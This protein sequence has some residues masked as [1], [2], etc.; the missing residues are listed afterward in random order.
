MAV[1]GTRLI[2]AH[3][4]AADQWA[5]DC[6]LL[7][8]INVSS[9]NKVLWRCADGHEFTESVHTRT[10]FQGGKGGQV[11]ACPFCLGH[12]Y[13]VKFRCGHT[14][15]YRASS[16]ENYPGR[17]EKAALVDCDRCRPQDEVWGAPEH[18]AKKDRI[19]KAAHPLPSAGLTPG[20][21]IESTNPITS[22]IEE[23]VRDALRAAGYEIP[24]VKMAV[25]CHHPNPDFHVL[26]ITP[27]IVLDKH[28][29][30]I[31]VDP[32]DAARRYGTH[33]GQEEKD[34][35]RNAL[36]EAV[37]WT[38]IRLRLGA[39]EG[40]NIGGRDVV[41]ESSGFT[42]G[43]QAALVDAIEDKIANRLA[44]ARIVKKGK[45]PAKA[46]RRS[47]VANIGPNRYS[48]DGHYFKWFPNLDQPVG[49]QMR[50]C[51]NGRYLYRPSGRDIV[52]VAEI[53]LHEIP[54]D[55]WH[56]SLETILEGM[57]PSITGT[58]RWPWGDDLL[59]STA[60]PDSQAIIDECES[61]AK[62][63]KATFYITTNCDDLT[64]FDPTALT[65]ADGTVIAKLAN[66]AANIGYRFASLE[67]LSGYRGD[68]QRITITREPADTESAQDPQ[69][70]EI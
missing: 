61:W 18:T 36:L 28:K 12:R 35:T 47:T 23:T 24:K 9:P 43:A 7:A 41:V 58:T 57:D 49:Q 33:A 19:W 64:G 50:L 16:A 11:D 63:D 66:E 26:S 62:I 65:T 25:L 8:T 46:Q 44:E 59:E 6:E 60:H 39:K 40:A 48:S 53:G 54:P 3:P 68:Y 31:E 29:I 37:G 27:D 2:E 52:Y 34:R 10:S 14:R 15:E 69:R 56:S 17:H 30:A 13:L 22:G 21:V 20:E 1:K 70:K 5:D 32:C 67:L 55:E 51:M 4:W 45:T 38:V 42:K